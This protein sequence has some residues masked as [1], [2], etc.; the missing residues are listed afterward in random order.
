MKQGADMTDVVDP[1]VRSRMMGAIKGKD[2]KPEIQ[3]RQYL[4]AQGFR[5][6]LHRRGLPGSPDLVLKRHSLVIFVHG[7][8]WHRHGKCFYAASPKTRPEFW[9]QKFEANMARDARVQNEL[10][11]LGWR[12]LV[13]WECGLKHL[14]LEDHQVPGLIRSLHADMQWPAIPPRIR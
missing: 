1:Q 11:Q 12:V 7:C 13:V 8:F 14:D 3:L 4:H 6:R 9:Q 5:Y 2:T 10:R